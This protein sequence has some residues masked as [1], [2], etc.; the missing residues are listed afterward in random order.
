MD[1]LKQWWDKIGLQLK[2]QIL[3]QGFLIIILIAAQEWIS[4]QFERQLMGAA[5]QRAQTVADGAIN[6][7]NTLMVTKAGEDDVISNKESRALFI[8]KMGASDNVKEMRIVRAKS[9]VEEFG[10]GLPQEQPV[11]DMDRATLSS[12]KVEYKVVTGNAGEASLRTVVPFIASKNFRTTNCL[13]CHGVSEG[14]VLGVASIVI[15]I[16][17]DLAAIKRVKSWIW[18]G[19]GILQV[20]LFFVIGWIVRMLL[21]QLGGEPA[22]VIA[23]VRQIAEG[24]LSADIRAR[25][26]DDRS[27]LAAMKQ[28]QTGLRRI[29]GGALETSDMLTRAAHSLV[30]SSRQVLSASGR[31]S[32]ASASTAASIEEMTVCIG[33]IS[34]N[35]ANARKHASGTGELA[36]DGISIAREV[37][38]EMGR[39]SEAVTA[40]ANVMTSL[41]EQ[42]RQISNI[43][44][45]IKEIADQTNLLALNAAIEAARAGEQGRGF[46]VV[47]DEVRKLAERTASSTQEIASMI[48]AIQRGTAD[49]VA[50]ME[51]GSSRVSEG[52]VMV[53][54]AG[55]SMEKIQGGVQEVLASIGDISSAL[56]EQSAASN[57]IAKNVEGIAQMTEET[58]R[59]VKDVATSADQLEQLA[60]SLKESVGQFRL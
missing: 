56:S 29:I 60:L 5:E 53:D 51:K 57:L 20:V 3:I 8:Q 39:I 16:K 9:I 24:N 55:A 32:D 4:V 22:Y 35:A 33:Q 18:I 42:S 26:S 48:E 43:I 41:G 12:G 45:V 36:Q 38:S 27:L 17:E 11:D 13:K 58:S 25:D 21:K 47:A 46:A 52:V 23:V 2:L 30:A 28:M 31:Q 10:P 50:G 15:D 14:E 40:S 1:G 37:V 19:Q 7:L 44:N 34:D 6:G 54:R 59:I 49:A